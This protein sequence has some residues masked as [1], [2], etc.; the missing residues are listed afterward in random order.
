MDGPL[1]PDRVIELWQSILQGFSYLVDRGRSAPLAAEDVC[2]RATIDEP[3]FWLLQGVGTVSS[4][5]DCLTHLPSTPPKRPPR[6]ER[7]EPGPGDLGAAVSAIAERH[8]LERGPV[9]LDH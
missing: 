3:H 2:L 8:D 9:P 5:Q 4:L 7:Q 1:A 6:L